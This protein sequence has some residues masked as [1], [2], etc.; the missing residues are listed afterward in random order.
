[1]SAVIGIA[2]LFCGFLALR[3]RNWLLRATASGLMLWCLVQGALTF[4][5]GGLFNVLIAAAV[6]LPHFLT[7]FRHAA[8]V[9]LTGIGVFVICGLVL[10]PRLQDLTGGS[11]EDRFTSTDGSRVELAEIDLRIFRENAVTGV[12]VGL[13]EEA[14]G[15]GAGLYAAHTEYSRMLAEHG[16]FGIG[17][18]VCMVWM[19]GTS[20]RRATGVVARAWTAALIAWSAAEMSHAAMRLSVTPFVFALAALVLIDND[21]PDPDGPSSAPARVKR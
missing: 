14:R 3:E 11:L 20:Y 6:A 10:L 7:R 18:L 8:G 19:A 21:R 13:S 4:S 12:G 2:A 1:V 16:L 5:R 17:A 9:L 15:D